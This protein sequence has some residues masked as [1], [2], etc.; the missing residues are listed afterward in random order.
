MGNAR[1]SGVAKSKSVENSEGAL[2]KEQLAKEETRITLTLS[3]D[4][5]LKLSGEAAATDKE[6]E[7]EEEEEEHNEDA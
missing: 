6:P 4:D 7:E 5:I 2:I 3:I 1:V